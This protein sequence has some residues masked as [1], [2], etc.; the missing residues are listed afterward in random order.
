MR[1]PVEQPDNLRIALD[2]HG[3]N[4]SFR[5]EFKEFEAHLLGE[6]A[7]TGIH[8]PLHQFRVEV[9]GDDGHRLLPDGLRGVGGRG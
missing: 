2:R 1:P 5:G 3:R 7:A 6:R 4:R 8:K 9:V